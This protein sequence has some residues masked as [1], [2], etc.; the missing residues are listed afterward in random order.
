MLNSCLKRG[1]KIQ[2]RHKGESGQ[3]YYGR[4]RFGNRFYRFFP[5]KAR[6]NADGYAAAAND[7]CDYGK[8][9]TLCAYQAV[10]VNGAAYARLQKL[11][12][13]ATKSDAGRE[14]LKAISEQ[15]TVL[16][17]DVAGKIRS[18]ISARPI[19]RFV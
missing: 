12:N 14:I 4:C 7:L 16:R 9:D 3:S 1:E 17:V 10:P 2:K 5:A 19:I 13:N 8:G 6:G 18:V 11:V 15:G